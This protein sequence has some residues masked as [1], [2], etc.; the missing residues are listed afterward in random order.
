MQKYSPE[1]LTILFRELFSTPDGKKVYDILKRRF[2]KP[3]LLPTQVTDGAALLPLT[4]M[5]V[6]E[7]NVIRYIEAI[8]EGESK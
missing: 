2:R 7:E 3:P 1:E 6:G 4:F 5:R 8:I